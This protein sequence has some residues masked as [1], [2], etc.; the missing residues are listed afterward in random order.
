MK[1]LVTCPGCERR[2]RM[3]IG[4]P[5]KHYVCPACST[6]FVLGSQIQSDE[7]GL[8]Q[9]V[10]FEV[11]D[12]NQP[13]K[14]P[15]RPAP[16]RKKT[17]PR[18]ATEPTAEPVDVPEDPPMV[19]DKV[20]VDIDLDVAAPK[21]EDPWEDDYRQLAHYA[22]RVTDP[23]PKAPE[24][25]TPP[26]TEPPAPESKGPDVPA[27][28]NKPNPPPPEAPKSS[29]SS[30]PKPPQAID[31]QREL[32]KKLAD[33]A[34][35]GFRTI[36][37]PPVE[38]RPEKKTPSPVNGSFEVVAKP[39]YEVVAALPKPAKAGFEVIAKPGY[40][41]VATPPEPVALPSDDFEKNLEDLLARRLESAPEP[42]KAAL[43]KATPGSAWIPVVQAVPEGN[44]VMAAAPALTASA[45]PALV[46][47]ARQVDDDVSREDAELERQ[48][49][50]QEMRETKRSW[51]AVYW[52][53]SLVKSALICSAI[54]L[55]L[56][57]LAYLVL[58]LGW[59]LKAGMVGFAAIAGIV[60][61]FAAGLA[62]LHEVLAL[63]GFGFSLGA[64]MRAAAKLWGTITLILAVAA[65]LVTSADVVVQLSRANAELVGLLVYPF[66][67]ICVFGQWFCYL[68]FLRAVAQALR[69]PSVEAEVMNTL[70]L[71]AVLTAVNFVIYVSMRIFPYIAVRIGME[72][73]DLGSTLSATLIVAV[74]FGI[75]LIALTAL[76]Q[77]RY[78]MCCTVV[79]N[80][81][82][83]KM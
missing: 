83:S 65:L 32:A 9:F 3:R 62:F 76:M 8:P 37:K 49:R 19:G 74:V 35:L 21:I 52:S 66:A 27:P 29:K 13:K 14:N 39:G 47:V 50:Q 68:F 80:A 59:S 44:G 75:M 54:A 72:T 42:P 67:G 24:S 78:I 60:F 1:C 70:K 69:K 46:A 82:R 6:A 7:P 48:E 30:T 26:A 28:P 17:A 25:P 12:E 5:G 61:I 20:H 22:P 58:A 73:G 55:A 18:D 77:V 33:L 16:E 79:A 71:M 51:P 11:L 4:P 2:L 41:V 64:P 56:I 43:P 57:V 36:P 53:V 38:K 40:E 63:I 34:D 15:K 31:K 45:T 23:P 10:A 81:V